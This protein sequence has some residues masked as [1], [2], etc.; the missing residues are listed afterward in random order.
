MGPA[1][2]IRTGLARS[3]QFSGRSTRREFWWFAPV[4]AIP[5]VTVG[6]QMSWINMDFWGVWRVFVL[7]ALSLPLLAALSR[8]LHD[9]GEPGEQAVY[10]FLP[11]VNLWLGYQLTYWF[12]MGGAVVGL[13]GL[14]VI[15]A[16]G[17]AL[18]F[19]P[20]YLV[21]IIV[22]LN[23]AASVIGMTLISSAPGPNRYGPNPLEV[24]P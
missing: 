13:G 24:T 16:I 1:Q 22:S 4:A 11:F 21:A 12:I 5:P 20:L 18:L 15:L 14:V 17:A 7:M 3:F 19:I 8:R 23:L 2:A 9:V 6:S 10:P